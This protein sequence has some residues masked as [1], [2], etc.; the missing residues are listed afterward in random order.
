MQLDANL[1]IL[2]INLAMNLHS[3]SLLSSDHLS[4]RKSNTYEFLGTSMVS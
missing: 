4:E 3:S 1:P 2:K